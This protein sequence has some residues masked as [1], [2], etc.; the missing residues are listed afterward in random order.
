MAEC[1]EENTSMQ[2]PKLV[3]FFLV[4]GLILVLAKELDKVAV[5]MSTIEETCN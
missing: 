5:V 1:T 3:V 4:L 2:N